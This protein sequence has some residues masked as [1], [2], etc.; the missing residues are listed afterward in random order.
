MSSWQDVRRSDVAELVYC[1][2]YLRV[3]VQTGQV[4]GA[5]IAQ[6]VE[7]I[8]Q[9]G[10][11][12]AIAELQIVT[13]VRGF[14]QIVVF[15]A[16]SLALGNI[17][18]SPCLIYIR[19]HLVACGE[20]SESAGLYLIAGALLFTLITVEDSQWNGNAHSKRVVDAASFVLAGQCRIDGATGNCEFC[21]R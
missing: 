18:S 6:R 20:Q 9:R 12:V 17:E 5:V 3:R 1:E 11:A 21:I 13:H 7:I 2:P 19:D 10:V 15:V 4:G 14:F 16:M 8:Q